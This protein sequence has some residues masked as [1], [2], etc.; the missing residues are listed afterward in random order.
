LANGHPE[1]VQSSFTTTTTNKKYR[2]HGQRSPSVEPNSTQTEREATATATPES[3][4]S[5]SEGH[6]LMAVLK[7]LGL[8]L[9][10]FRHGILVGFYYRIQRVQWMIDVLITFRSRRLGDRDEGGIL[11]LEV[12]LWKRGTECFWIMV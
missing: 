5:H 11:K 3:A 10:D 9:L 7:K 4:E 8:L 6:L 2:K 12:D 1:S